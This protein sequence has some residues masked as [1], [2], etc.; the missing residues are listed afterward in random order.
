MGTPVTPS[1]INGAAAGKKKKKEFTFAMR[2]S[3]NANQ[4]PKA[5]MGVVLFDLAL[6]TAWFVYLWCYP[7]PNKAEVH[8]HGP[9][10]FNDYIIWFTMAE[11]ALS[12]A[13]LIVYGRWECHG[14]YI[15][16]WQVQTCFISFSIRNALFKTPIYF[17]IVS[18]ELILAY[19]IGLMSELLGAS[20]ARLPPFVPKRND[21]E[22]PK[23]GWL[24]PNVAKWASTNAARN[25]VTSVL[26]LSKFTFFFICWLFYH[27]HVEIQMHVMDQLDT[28]LYILGGLTVLTLLPNIIVDLSVLP[29]FINDW[30]TLK[31]A[32]KGCKTD[33]FEVAI[34]DEDNLD[35][36]EAQGEMKLKLKDHK[37][38]DVT[39]VIPCYMPNEEEIIFDVLD[40][41]REQARRY[42]GVLKVLVV[43]NSPESHYAVEDKFNELMKEWPDF[44]WR[45]DLLSTSKCD[46]LNTAI[47]HLDTE[48]ALFNDA[49][50]MVSAEAF[51]RASMHI[52]GGNPEDQVDI[53]QCHSTYCKEDVAGKPESGD[54]CFG[55][56]ITMA[57]SSKPRNMAT[58]GLMFKH[59]P[60]NGRGGF[61]R[62]SAVKTVG[63]D[64]RSIGED[65]DAG[66]RAI[67]YY[68]AKG[69][70]D[71]N[72]LCQ[73]REAPDCASLT[74]QRIRWETA[75]LEMRRTFPWILRSEY[76]GKFEAFVLIW[77]QLYANANLPLQFLPM[78][79]WIG[80]SMIITKCYLFKHVLGGTELTWQTLC[81]AP[82]VV[83]N[84]TIPATT[85]NEDCVGHFKIFGDEVALPLAFIGF[86]SIFAVMFI[87][88]GVECVLRCGATRY[89]PRLFFC[90]NA[91]FV[92]PFT[93]GPFLTYCQFGA[94]KDYCFGDAKFIATKR[95]PSSDKLSSMGSMNNVGSKGSLSKMADV[96]SNG[97]LAAPLLGGKEKGGLLN[98]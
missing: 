79:M 18:L 69:I 56:I 70:L 3:R 8:K 47:E 91:V 50:T 51:V 16:F 84:S 72:M 22:R 77:S 86:F 62:V 95:S 4:N 54:F 7:R 26:F 63:F 68:G 61:W 36:P 5:V 43:W 92:S 96:S 17:L 27:T 78:Q 41:Y 2:N 60:F 48:V 85:A 73:E 42:P 87:I 93:M 81:G 98:A 34:I 94:L 89:R 39:V 67:A 28:L 32:S 40:Y 59:S 88:W 25:A 80:I 46:N 10:V 9:L 35:D 55:G 13:F 38:C 31:E 74:K 30:R 90:L 14:H 15:T 21:K 64:H 11:F 12:S 45:R 57:D 76:Y 53:A 97:N 83:G 29:E 82:T 20:D 65:H 23:Y 1:T 24:G 33:P 37:C 75:A 19:V 44:K 66:Y 6:R 58:Q 49:D 52:T 71:P